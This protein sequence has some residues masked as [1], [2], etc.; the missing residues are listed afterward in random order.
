MHR[1]QISTCFF[2]L[3]WVL[4]LFLIVGSTFSEHQVPW[5]ICIGAP[6]APLSNFSNIQLKLSSFTGNTSFVLLQPLL[7]TFILSFSMSLIFLDASCKWNHTTCV[8]LHSAY[9]L[10]IMATPLSMQGLS[11]SQTCTGISFFYSIT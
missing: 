7:N 6:Q 5:N 3:L 1:S 9:I 2:F 11:M 8:H 10:Y 4:T